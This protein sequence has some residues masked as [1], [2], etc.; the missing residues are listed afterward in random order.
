M[1]AIDQDTLDVLF[2]LAKWQSSYFVWKYNF[3]N[4]R[5]YTLMHGSSKNILPL[6]V[7]S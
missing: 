1:I 3:G 2:Y 7:D 4:M 5:Y 6:S